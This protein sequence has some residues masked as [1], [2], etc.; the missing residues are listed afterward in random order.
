MMEK[1]SSTSVVWTVNG[2]IEILH[3]HLFQ[4]KRQQ[5]D[6]KHEPVDVQEHLLYTH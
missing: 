6:P 2:C 4:M 1:Y 3:N 5:F